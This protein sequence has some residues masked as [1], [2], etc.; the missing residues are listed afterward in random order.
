MRAIHRIAPDLLVENIL[1]V[2]CGRSGLTLVLYSNAQ[3]V[4][5]DFGGQY[6]SAPCNQRPG[7]RFVCGDATDL[8]FEDE[9]FDPVTMFD[10]LERVPD[11]R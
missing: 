7:V 8:P 11:D 10:L 4:N 9:S 6:A 2:R 3:I 5:I 1:E